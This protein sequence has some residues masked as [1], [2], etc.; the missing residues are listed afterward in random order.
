M[1]YFGKLGYSSLGG[2]R[3]GRFAGIPYGSIGGLYSNSLLA[4]ANPNAAESDTAGASGSHSDHNLDDQT[5]GAPHYASEREDPS[6]TGPMSG[7]QYHESANEQ[8]LGAANPNDMM[9]QSPMRDSNRMANDHQEMYRSNGPLEH[10]MDH[11]NHGPTPPI[12]LHKLDTQNTLGMAPMYG[13]ESRMLG[14][15]GPN[16]MPMPMPMP[17]PTP[18]HMGGG[19]F[20]GQPYAYSGSP[21]AY[22]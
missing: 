20:V 19:N 16:R 6:R 4:A 17:M 22:Y 1:G 8:M 14:A 9:M 2:I 18:S 10:H 11:P 15:E 21:Y 7:A 12:I 5:V 3:M 13:H